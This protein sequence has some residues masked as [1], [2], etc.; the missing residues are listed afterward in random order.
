M[1][2]ASAPAKVIV[3]GEH[4]V[5]HD[6]LGVSAAVGPNR[7]YVKISQGDRDNVSIESI[8]LDLRESRNKKSVHELIAELDKLRKEERYESIKTVAKADRLAPSFVVAGKT[9]EC[10]RT[11]EPVKIDI[12]CKV[13]K[14]LGSSSSVFSSIA[15]GLSRYLDKDPPLE[16]M[17]DLANEGDN[18]AH[19]KASGIDAKTVTRGY[20]NTYKKSEGIKGLNVDFEGPLVIVESGESARTGET[21]TYL[22]EL[23]NRRPNLVNP[24]LNRLEGITFRGLDALKSQDLEAIGKAMTDYAYELR[25][26]DGMNAEGLKKVI[27]ST[28]K[29][30][31]IID[32]ALNSKALGAKPTG[33]WGGGCCI[34]LPKDNY[35]AEDLV[36]VF[37]NRGFNS[38]QAKLG[39]EGVKEEFL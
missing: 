39:V 19:G 2:K 36:E 18:V 38:F 26:V 16:D 17:G 37:Q 23:L 3:Y 20:W 31:Q 34:V 9:M 22:N 8:D 35:Q 25:K 33:G 27:F 29:L 30:E 4:A 12:R 13:P 6:R 28:P 7:T 11:Y 14:N 21:V 24:M 15:F 5:V 10:F 1:I 32:I